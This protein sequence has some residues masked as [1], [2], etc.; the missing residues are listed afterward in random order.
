MGTGFR[1][2]SRIHHAYWAPLTIPGPLRPFGRRREPKENLMSQSNTP[3]VS[4][5]LPRSE[6]F[7]EA[8]TARSR[9]RDDTP[10]NVTQE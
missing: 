5:P 10:G 6:K 2:A 3:P 7:Q 8:L 4:V 9:L 1:R